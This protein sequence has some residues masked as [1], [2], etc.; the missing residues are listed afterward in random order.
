MSVGGGAASPAAAGAGPAKPA[1]AAKPAAGSDS[2]EELD[3]F[4][5]ATP[6]EQAAAEERA[7]VVAAA[8]ARS[9]EKAL[10]SKSMIVLDVKPWDDETSMEALEKH[11]R[12]VVKDGLLWGASKLVP[13]GF[14]IKKLQITAVIEDNKVPSFDAIIEDEL[15][16]DGENEWIQS[17]VSAFG[18]GAC[19]GGPAL[20][21]PLF[22]PPDA[23]SPCC[24]QV[25]HR[26]LQQAVSGG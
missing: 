1:A 8:K 4:G 15:V 7:K 26:V 18:G 6:E 9:A 13:V 17:C 22:S 24:L 20:R 25:R 21:A 5:D 3:L 2:D 23:Q 16:Q 12:S 11:V 14:G 10:L 19:D